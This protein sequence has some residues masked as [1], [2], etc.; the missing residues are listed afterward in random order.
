MRRAQHIRTLFAVQHPESRPGEAGG[1]P[2]SRLRLWSELFYRH[3][4]RAERWFKPAQ[5]DSSG[6]QR[7]SGADDL[8]CTCLTMALWQEN[9]A[10]QQRPNSMLQNL[11][12]CM[13]EVTESGAGEVAPMGSEG[14]A[15]A[16]TG[17]RVFSPTAAWRCSGLRH[18]LCWKEDM[19]M[20]RF[21]SS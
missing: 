1:S 21:I 19:Q 2:L 15:P 17:H 14:Q 10:C 18:T 4:P 9:P 6:K 16:T 13:S 7:H 3:V 20:F 12:P 8:C 5:E 11:L